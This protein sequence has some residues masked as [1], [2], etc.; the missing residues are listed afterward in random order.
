MSTWARRKERIATDPEFRARVY[1]QQTE[2]RKRRQDRVRSGL[3]P[4]CSHV[5]RD[6]RACWRQDTHGHKA[7]GVYDQPTAADEVLADLAFDA[8]REDRVF[9]TRRY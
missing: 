9:G 7:A 1:R 2:S 8:A 6:G 4:V 5:Y 3:G